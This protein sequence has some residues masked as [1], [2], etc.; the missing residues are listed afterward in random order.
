[1]AWA[2]RLSREALKDYKNLPRDAQERVGRAIDGLSVDPFMGDVKAL[3]GPEWKGLYRKRVG[4]YRIIFAADPKSDV[5]GVTAILR[6]SE[7]TYR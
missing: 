1:M 7:K 6:R 4:P 2:V 5:V 3:K